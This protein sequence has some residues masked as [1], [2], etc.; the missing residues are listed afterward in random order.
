MISG[1][2][3]NDRRKMLM[4]SA[5]T[6]ELLMWYFLAISGNPGAIIEVDAGSTKVYNETYHKVNMGCE[7]QTFVLRWH[8]TSIFWQW[9]S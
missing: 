2:I 7:S 4:V 1:P 8:L 5:T 6:V 9:T 3:A